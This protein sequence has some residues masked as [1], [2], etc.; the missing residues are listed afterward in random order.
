MGGGRHQGDQ[1][2]RKFGN[3]I[4][5]QKEKFSVKKGRHRK[6][7]MGMGMEGRARWTATSG[8]GITR[9]K[10]MEKG[11]MD[12]HLRR[13]DN[14]EEIRGNFAVHVLHKHCEPDCV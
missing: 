3:S 5:K 1:V 11:E 4:Q 2:I 13:R 8:G 7:E 9:K 12:R 10:F 14:Q 6:G